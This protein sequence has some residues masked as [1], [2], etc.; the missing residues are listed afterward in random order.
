MIWIWRKKPRNFEELV[1]QRPF[2]RERADR[3]FKF[4][5]PACSKKRI[6]PINPRGSM[7]IHYFRIALCTAFF[8]LVTWPLFEF[9]GVVSFVPF[10]MIFE[11]YFRL[12]LRTLLPCPNCG[13][14]PYLLLQNVDLAKKEVKE[15]WERKLA[16]LKAAE[17][18][19]KDQKNS[20]KTAATAESTK[21]APPEA[22]NIKDVASSIN[23]EGIDAPE[24][25]K[26]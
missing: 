12:K 8:T 10:W 14:D 5:C 19:E 22:L 21:H 13:F 4:Y 15:H 24:V 7:M 6:I 20:K 9:K 2:F 26:K 18:I 1:T 23:D 16:P 11:T 25:L 3:T 17:K